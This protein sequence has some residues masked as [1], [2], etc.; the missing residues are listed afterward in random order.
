MANLQIINHESSGQMNSLLFILLCMVV[1]CGWLCLNH[2]CRRRM[3]IALYIGMLL[4]CNSSNALPQFNT[5]Q[6]TGDTSAES[7]DIGNRQKQL[8]FS[9]WFDDSGIF[10]SGF[11]KLQFQAQDKKRLTAYVYRAKNFN[12]LNGPIWF[13]MHG[14]KRNADHYLAVAAPVAERYQAMAIAI[15]FSKRDYPRGNDYTLGVTTHG[16]VDDTA[17]K[18]GR[19]RKSGTYLYDEVESVFEAVRRSL[20]GRQPGYYL[21]GHSAGA[22][23]THR[24]IT[25]TPQARVVG[26]VAANAGWYTL[27]AWGKGSQFAMPYGLRGSPLENTSLQSLLAAPLTLLLGTRDTTTPSTDPL[28]RGTPQAMIQ[29]N[30][31]LAR[32]LNY[33]KMGEASAQ[34]MHTPFAWRLAMAPGAGHQVRQVIASAGFLLFSPKETPCHSSSATDA[35]GLVINEM[36]ADPPRGNRGDANV[37]GVRDASTDEFVEII[38]TSVNPLCLTGWTLSDASGKLRHLFPLGAELRPGKALVIFGGGVPTG[39][40][41]GAEVQ[42][43]TSKKG[44]SLSRKGDV[45]T[46]RDAVGSVATQISWGDCAGNTCA[47]EHIKRDLGFSGSIVRW[48]ELVGNWRLHRDI[49]GSDFS[50]GLRVNGS[51]WW[52]EQ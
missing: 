47:K 12:P 36:L 46:L 3:K 41:G 13:V 15:E 38:N 17:F 45:L 25:F 24:L 7:R 20:G 39:S 43:A 19:W 16:R 37:D 6:N 11:G 31:R 23:F 29:G 22:Q 44:L 27:P 10:T 5:G 14:A 8:K 42:W 21:F 51:A 1:I 26:A 40:F 28:V 18:L 35:G 30:T 49:S 48:P 50:P 33:F 32:G 9:V 4:A 34:A 2:F 52:H